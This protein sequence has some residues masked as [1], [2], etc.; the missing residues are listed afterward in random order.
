MLDTHTHTN[1]QQVGSRGRRGCDGVDAVNGAVNGDR[2]SVV[3]RMG[4][5]AWRMAMGGSMGENRS[6]AEIRVSTKPN[7]SV[8]RS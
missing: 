8:R 1:M 3:H 6:A 5:G 2:P 4:M 7:S